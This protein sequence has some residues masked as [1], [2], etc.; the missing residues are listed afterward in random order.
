MFPRDADTMRNA[1]KIQH[2]MRIM[3]EDQNTGGFFLALLRKNAL[4]SL[5]KDEAKPEEPTKEKEMADEETKLA[6]KVKLNDGSSQ[7]LVPEQPQPEVIKI[8]KKKKQNGY[9]VPKMDYKPFA[10]KFPEAW[11]AVRDMY[12]LEDVV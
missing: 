6:A 10:E 2:S 11:A 4:V 8:E 3:P 12:G 5:K 1:I 7:P 9:A